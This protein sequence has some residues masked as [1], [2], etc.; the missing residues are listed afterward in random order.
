LPAA[1]GTDPGF[2]KFGK[3][4]GHST[5]AKL[6]E[7]LWIVTGLFAE[8]YVMIYKAWPAVW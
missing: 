8:A 2:A 5:E 6:D 3:A 7:V 4:Y 1:D